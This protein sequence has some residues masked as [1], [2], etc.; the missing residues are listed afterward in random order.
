MVRV[1]NCLHVLT[2][3]VMKRQHEK[4]DLSSLLN[5][6]MSQVVCQDRTGQEKKGF[7]CDENKNCRNIKLDSIGLCRMNDLIYW[8]IRRMADLRRS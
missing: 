1:I 6:Q 7:L 5:W 3:S 2:L 8:V 4:L